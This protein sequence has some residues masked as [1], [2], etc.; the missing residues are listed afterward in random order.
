MTSRSTTADDEDEPE[1]A[2]E[3]DA[4][5]QP[6]EEVPVDAEIDADPDADL[7]ADDRKACPRSTT[8]TTAMT[9]SPPAS[10]RLADAYDLV[11]FDLD[12]VIYLSDSAVPGAVEA[13]QRLHEQGR[14]IAYATNNA[15]R[16]AAEV[17]ELLRG[18]GVP[19]EADEVLTS[20]AAAARL[21]ADRL[22]P[23]APGA[24]G[25]R[26]G[27]APGGLRRRPDPGQQRR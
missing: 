25:R 3:V 21:L 2:V 24:G 5:G 20:A 27:A 26:R 7:D 18:L 8:P 22:K 4:E 19:A 6:D 9:M 13:V 17:A 1:A 10:G 16:R 15:S 12:G 14:S 11:I 23:G